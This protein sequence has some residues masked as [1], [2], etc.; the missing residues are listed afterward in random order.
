MAHPGRGQMQKF[1]FN[2]E[3]MTRKHVFG[4][5]TLIGRKSKGVASNMKTG[6]AYFFVF[7]G[8]LLTVSGAVFIGMYIWGAVISR[9]GEAD[10]SLVFWYLPILFIGAGAVLGGLFMFR[11][12]LAR[13]RNKQAVPQSRRNDT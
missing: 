7:L 1:F 6:F 2:Y 13:T 12:G 5:R 3:P 9:L 4:L 10:Q 8:G 11:Q